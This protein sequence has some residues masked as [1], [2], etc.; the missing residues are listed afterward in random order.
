MSLKRSCS[1]SK[2]SKIGSRLWKPSTP[3]GSH[4]QQPL[5]RWIHPCGCTTA[6]RGIYP[7][8][9]KPATVPSIVV[10]T[11]MTWTHLLATGRK[12]DLSWDASALGGCSP[13]RPDDSAGGLDRAKSSGDGSVGD[14]NSVA[15]ARTTSLTTQSNEQLGAAGDGL[16]ISPTAQLKDE[17]VFKGGRDV[18]A[19]NHGS[20]VLARL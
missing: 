20:E 18:M 12:D 1:R 15:K 10:R 4:F 17:L 8:G 7:R 5:I 14:V 11:R 13:D 3:I 9:R 2:R 19:S 16:R 6:D